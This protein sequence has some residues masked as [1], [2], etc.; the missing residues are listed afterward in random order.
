MLAALTGRE[1]DI[2]NAFAATP[3]HWWDAVGTT[4]AAR[5]GQWLS[6]ANGKLIWD[7]NRQIFVEGQAGAQ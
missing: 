1:A 5:W 7:S 4:A 6:E 3:E 2:V